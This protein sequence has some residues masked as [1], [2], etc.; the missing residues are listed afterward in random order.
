ME[1]SEHLST[2]GCV[3]IYTLMHLT[4]NLQHSPNSHRSKLKRKQNGTFAYFKFKSILKLSAQT[5]D[6]FS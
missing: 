3:D 5:D 2:Q 6:N 4:Q 1:P